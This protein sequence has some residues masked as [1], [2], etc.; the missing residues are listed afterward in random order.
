[1]TG[2]LTL[3]L[4]LFVTTAVVHKPLNAHETE[5]KWLRVAHY[6]LEHLVVIQLMIII[7]EYLKGIG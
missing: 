6:W 2:L 4:V 1:M 7:N 5:K 3:F